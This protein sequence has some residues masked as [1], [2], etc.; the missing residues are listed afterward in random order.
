MLTHPDTLPT[1]LVRPR[2]ACTMLSVGLTRC[3]ELMNTGELQSFKDGKAR[4]ITVSSIKAYIDRRL[5]GQ[6]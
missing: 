1:L 5:E 6:L 2:Q 3:Y 4:K